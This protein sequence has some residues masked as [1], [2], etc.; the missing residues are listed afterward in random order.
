MGQAWP[1]VMQIQRPAAHDPGPVDQAVPDHVPHHEVCIDAGAAV[2]H[3]GD[4]PAAQVL[5]LCGNQCPRQR[6]GPW[7][8]W[9]NSCSG[10]PDAHGRRSGRGSGSCRC[11]PRLR[12]LPPGPLR[13]LSRRECR[14]HRTAHPSAGEP[15]RYRR[16]VSH[17][18]S[19]FSL[20]F[21]FLST[22]KG[23]CLPTPCG[24]FPGDSPF[25]CDPV[26]LISG[27]IVRQQP[28]SWPDAL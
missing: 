2:A 27:L 9:G 17:F 6:C 7:G 12:R 23:G 22:G 13:L 21:S 10:S 18:G 4:A 20:V 26:E 8:R 15:G 1:P 5:H 14:F 16:T 25:R 24:A 28:S 19:A 11:R 3:R